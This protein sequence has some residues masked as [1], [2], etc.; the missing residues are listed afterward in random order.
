VCRALRSRGR[1][2]TNRAIAAAS[3]ADRAGVPATRAAP[4]RARA[5]AA[6]A[7]MRGAALDGASQ[8]QTDDRRKIAAPP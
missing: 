8:V 5:H 3:S 7:G 4:D 2:W 1:R 6:F